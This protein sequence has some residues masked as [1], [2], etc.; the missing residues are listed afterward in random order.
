MNEK[1]KRMTA[2]HEAG[3]AIVGH[4]LP[5]S[6][7]V[8]KVTIIPRGMA[9][10]LTQQLPIDERH[11][12]S[13]EFA[14]IVISVLMGGRCAEEIIFKHQTTGAG[15]DIEKATGMARKMVCEWG[16]SDLG[17]LSFGR[18]EGEI[19]L[20]RDFTQQQEYSSNTAIRI[21]E[22]VSKIVTQNYQRAR[23]I[24]QDNLAELHR[25]AETLLEFESLDGDQIDRILRGEKLEPPKTPLPPRPAPVTPTV[26]QGGV[27][28]GAIPEPGKA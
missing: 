8:H 3:H 2:Y 10:G 14:E 9:L 15:D 17:P 25:L 18:K 16:M 12:H 13:K 24:L 11:I 5:D 20:G 21:D 6:D 23:K 26:P 28:L 19:F 7:P 1:E 27:V 22:E 4:L